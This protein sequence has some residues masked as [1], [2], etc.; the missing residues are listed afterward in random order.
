MDEI[1]K[2]LELVVPDSVLET[3]K[4]VPAHIKLHFLV[5]ICCHQGK[6]DGREKDLLLE[7]LGRGSQISSEKVEGDAVN[8]LSFVFSRTRVDRLTYDDSEWPQLIRFMPNHIL[9]G[10]LGLAAP[11]RW[12]LAGAGSDCEKPIAGAGTGTV[13]HVLQRAPTNQLRPCCKKRGRSYMGGGPV[14]FGIWIA[15]IPFACR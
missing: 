11:F 5:G 10:L 7:V 14:L 15:I 6:L 9:N 13:F 1:A 8:M 4:L 3:W 12:A 2:R